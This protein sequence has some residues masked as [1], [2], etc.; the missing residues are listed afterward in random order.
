[1]GLTIGSDKTYPYSNDEGN[2]FAKNL[3]IPDI[4]F[5]TFH[6]YTSDCE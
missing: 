2:D 6:L 1:M 5:A 3:E 4:D